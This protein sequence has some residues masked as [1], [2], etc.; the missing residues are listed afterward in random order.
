MLNSASKYSYTQ[1]ININNLGRNTLN[2]LYPN[3]LQQATRFR[4]LAIRVRRNFMPF[5]RCREDE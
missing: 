1:K 3:Q 4:M 5:R 2:P